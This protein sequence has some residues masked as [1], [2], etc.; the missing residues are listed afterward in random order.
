MHQNAFHKCHILQCRNVLLKPP[1]T[2]AEV[3]YPKRAP[4]SSTSEPVQESMRNGAQR[5]LKQLGLSWRHPRLHQHGFEIWWNP[6]E[7]KGVDTDELETDRGRIQH[8]PEK[9]EAGVR[10][11]EERREPASASGAD[12]RKN[13]RPD[14]HGIEG[15]VRNWEG[16]GVRVQHYLEPQES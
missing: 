15:S 7:R 6:L 3:N 14:I 10:E 1:H 11:A 2:N 8:I 5:I 13:R 16:R 4:K 12:I 9:R